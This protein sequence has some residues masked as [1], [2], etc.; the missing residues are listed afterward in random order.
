MC[1]NIRSFSLV[2]HDYIFD[3]ELEIYVQ[4]TDDLKA[5]IGEL[6][7]IKGVETVKQLEQ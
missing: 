7:K 6:K 2:S 1:V 5:L 4:N 3:A